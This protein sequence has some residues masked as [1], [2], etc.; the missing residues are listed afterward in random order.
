[1]V[2]G[3]LDGQTVVVTGASSGIGRAIALRLAAEGA[4][5][6]LGDR[7]EEPREGG[8]PT[9]ELI[10][11]AGGDA[12]FLVADVSRAADNEALVAAALEA[13]GRLDVLVANAGIGGRV[14]MLHEF[15]EEDWDAVMA[16][17]LRGAFLS[18]R[19]AIRQMLVQEPRGDVRGR[20]I[21]IAS[22]HGMIGPPRYPAY[23]ASKGGLLNLV[24]QAAVDYGPQGIYVNA[25]APGKIVRADEDE[26]TLDYAKARTPF[27]RLGRPE[28]V[29]AAVL[30]LAA[31]ASYVSG[32][33]LL[34]DGGWMAY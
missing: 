24:R 11:E 29:A 10:A 31:E 33:A 1:V 6:I 16:V 12:R 3:R 20:C 30:F 25:V 32:A 17:N 13:T 23:A 34:V 15:S 19:A 18:L 22:Q 2:V 9:R 21:A 7:G 8:R 4:S 27:S 5:V 14:G 26:S 28:D